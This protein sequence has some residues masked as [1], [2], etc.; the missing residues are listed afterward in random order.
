[1]PRANERTAAKAAGATHYFNNKPYPRGH[2]AL[3]FTN[4]GSCTICV[5]EK[6][7]ARY[8]K[9]P[10]RWREHGSRGAKA[11]Y[12]K[13]KE[14]AAESTRRWQS[15]F[16]EKV[17]AYKAANKARRRA[18]T[19]TGASWAAVEAWKAEQKKVCYW[20]GAKCADDFHVDHYHP[21]AK[22]GAHEV[23]NLVIACPSC[24]RHKSAK[25]PYQFAAT[26]G[27]LF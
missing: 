26:V 6:V 19:G 1:M 25:D 9:D 15:Q 13:N 8:A 17:R 7:R 4:S 22:G 5:R 21:L 2:I 12:A 23:D 16:P 24:N 14:R 18:V 20:C 11:W 27:R 10:D 3:R